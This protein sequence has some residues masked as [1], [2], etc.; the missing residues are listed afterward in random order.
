MNLSYRTA[1]K[2]GK[3]DKPRSCFS[4][5]FKDNFDSIKW[6][7]RSKP[8]KPEKPNTKHLP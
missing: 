3:G 6:V 4:N 8:V 5:N 1:R 7:N 2:S